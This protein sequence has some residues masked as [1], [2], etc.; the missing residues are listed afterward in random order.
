MLIPYCSPAI[1]SFLNRF[2]AAPGI[3]PGHSGISLLTSRTNNRLNTAQRS[4]RW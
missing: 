1:D 3:Y 4:L 2:R